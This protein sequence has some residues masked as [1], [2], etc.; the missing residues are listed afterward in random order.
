MGGVSMGLG[1]ASPLPSDTVRVPCQ[2]P[3][4]VHLGLQL[5]EHLLNHPSCPAVIGALVEPLLLTCVFAGCARAT[6]S[7]GTR[8]CGTCVVS[9]KGQV[10]LSWGVW[11]AGH[12]AGGL[13]K[14][15]PFEV[16]WAFLSVPRRKQG[17]GQVTRGGRPPPPACPDHSGLPKTEVSGQEDRTAQHSR[18]LGAGLC[19]LPSV[20]GRTQTLPAGQQVAASPRF[21]PAQMASPAR[22]PQGKAVVKAG[23]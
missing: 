15:L 16:S 7:T 4:P 12:E 8:P 14:P 22:R 5:L 19:L 2:H 21:S 3:S 20:L 1:T 10:A 23:P 17:R 6:G 11:G 9:W 18:P 13:R